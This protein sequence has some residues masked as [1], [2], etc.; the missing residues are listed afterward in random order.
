MSDAPLSMRAGAPSDV[1]GGRG[2]PAAEATGPHLQA[3]VSGFFALLLE[4]LP[5]LS[6]LVFLGQS[7]GPVAGLPTMVAVVVA[8]R[9]RSFC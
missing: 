6:V 4:L 7:L 1:G 2:R 3:E 5:L 9:S 8:T